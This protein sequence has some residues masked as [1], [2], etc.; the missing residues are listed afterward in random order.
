MKRI[1]AVILAAGTSSRL[2]FNKLTVKIDDKPVISR[3]VEPF[4]LEGIDRI[5]VVMNPDCED[6]ERDLEQVARSSQITF[7]RNMN[8]RQGMSSSVKATIPFIKDG[9]AVFFH[10]GDKPFIESEL[11]SRMLDLYLEGNSPI[12]IPEYEGEKG[13]PVLMEIGPHLDEMEWLEGDR[14]LREIVDKH[15]EDVVSIEGD[16]GTVFDID[17]VEALNIL[18]KRGFRVEKG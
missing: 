16:E 3:A 1:Y 18:E 4:C 6:I 11:V 13:H 10:L 5:F 2:G 7:V 15:S 8:F 9:D 14:G 12:I 17:T